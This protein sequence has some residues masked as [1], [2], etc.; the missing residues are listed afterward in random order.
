[1]FEF[2]GLLQ[3]TFFIVLNDID[4]VIERAVRLLKL[5]AR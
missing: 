2:S 5:T 1:V 4:H 3:P